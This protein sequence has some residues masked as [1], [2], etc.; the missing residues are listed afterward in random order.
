MTDGATTADG[1]TASATDRGA[2]RSLAGYLAAVAAG[3]PTPGGGSVVAVVAAMGAALGAMVGNLSPSAADEH[4]ELRDAPTALHRLRQRLL[5]LAAADE[6]AYGAYRA[7][8]ALPKGTEQERAARSTAR[9]DALLAATDI[10]ESVAAAC[11]ELAGVLDPV[12]RLGNR[13]LLADAR[14]AAWLTEAALRGALL[15]LRG[16]AGLIRDAATADRYRRRADELE[17]AGT[18]ALARVLA[19]AADRSTQQ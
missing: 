15:N 5:P 8:V 12:A 3:E 14:I 16:N 9:A 10:P 11:V 17:A 2:E 4:P 19:A 1:G 13:H 6:A 7:A 18:A